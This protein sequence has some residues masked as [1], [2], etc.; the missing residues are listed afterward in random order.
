MPGKSFCEVGFRRTPLI[1]LLDDI[2]MGAGLAPWAYG[3]VPSVLLAF[4]GGGLLL[5]HRLKR[6]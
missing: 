5:S 1:G 6:H 4:I 3:L 2:Y